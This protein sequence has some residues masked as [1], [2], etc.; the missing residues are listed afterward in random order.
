MAIVYT[1]GMMICRAALELSKKGIPPMIFGERTDCHTEGDGH[2]DGCYKVS[3]FS[4]SLSVLKVLPVF[5]FAYNVHC[6]HSLVFAEMGKPKSLTKMDAVSAYALGFCAIVY[7]ICGLVGY[8][9][10]V[11]HYTSI[12]S[13]LTTYHTPHTILQVR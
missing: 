7:I 1:V 9:C 10:V 6:T 2:S 5:C 3:S 8:W 13:P 12:H 4:L 11:P